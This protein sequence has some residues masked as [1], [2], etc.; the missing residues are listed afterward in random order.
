M[1]DKPKA[2]PSHGHAV[3]ARNS[4]AE[5]LL[6]IMDELS[7]LQK[8]AEKGEVTRLDVALSVNRMYAKAT[9]SLTLLVQ[10]EAPIH[11]SRFTK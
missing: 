11:P 3:D 7:A 10:Q 1:G 4:V 8:R 5:N 2:W 6:E 9:S